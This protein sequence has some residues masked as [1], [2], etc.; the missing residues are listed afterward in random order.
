MNNKERGINSEPRKGFGIKN[1]LVVAATLGILS[2]AVACN[3]QKQQ[4]EAEQAI[5]ACELEKKNLATLEADMATA[6]VILKE[7]LEE[8]T[9]LLKTPRP[10]DKTKGTLMSTPTPTSTP[11]PIEE[12]GCR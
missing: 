9:A 5:A 3:G 1:K 4:S 8:D 7:A 10:I 12:T 2:L 6:I 11:E